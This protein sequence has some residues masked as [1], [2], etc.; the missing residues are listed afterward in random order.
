[1]PMYSVM[2]SLGALFAIESFEGSSLEI[3]Y[4]AQARINLTLETSS[5]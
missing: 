3:H 1:M 5:A 4:T 2:I